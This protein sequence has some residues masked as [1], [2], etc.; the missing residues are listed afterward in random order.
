MTWIIISLALVVAF[1]PMLYLLPTREQRRLA[2][3]RGTARRAGLVVELK[4]VR[5]LDATAGERVSAG[6]RVRSPTHKSVAYSLPLPSMPRYVGSWRLLR[7]ATDEWRFDDA[8]PI[9][10]EPTLVA[11]LTPFFAALPAD[12]VAV[13]CAGRAL[14]CYWLERFP[15]DG[16]TV[17]SLRAALVV[18][19]E[20]LLAKDAEVA[21]RLAED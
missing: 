15:A 10:G 9:P 19:A 5:K 16:E 17:K 1:G 6:G 2:A 7:S 14:S 21:A 4:P 11:T 13:E 3:L 8:L 18:L 20:Q 12:T